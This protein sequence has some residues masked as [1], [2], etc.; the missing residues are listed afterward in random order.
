[1]TNPIC[2]NPSTCTVGLDHALDASILPQ[3]SGPPAQIDGVTFGVATMSQNPPHGGEMH[4]DG[5]EVLYLISGRANVVFLD[6]PA[7]DME[8]RPGNGVIVPKGTWHRVDIVEPCQI[9][10]VT[11]GPNKEIRPLTDDA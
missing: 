2:F 6:N 1:M 10:Y 11:P 9:V 5:D 7:G 4:P 3:D 8:L